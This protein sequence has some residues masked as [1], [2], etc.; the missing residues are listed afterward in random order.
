MNK[1]IFLESKNSLN[2]IWDQKPIRMF[3]FLEI[4]V[5]QTS[6]FHYFLINYSL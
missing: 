2:Q 1:Y 6:V 3:S 4:L 5:T